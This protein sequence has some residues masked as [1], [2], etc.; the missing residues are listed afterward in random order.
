MSKLP[1]IGKK[2]KY[3][4]DDKFRWVDSQWEK[5]MTE[6]QELKAENAQLQK[7][8]ETCTK[9]YSKLWDEHKNLK[10]YLYLEKRKGDDDE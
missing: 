2:P 3:N 10:E 9:H 7:D 6:Q 5:F 4:H 1:N 8:L